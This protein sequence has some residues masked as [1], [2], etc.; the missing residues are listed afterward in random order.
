MALTFG[1]FTHTASEGVQ[2]VNLPLAYSTTFSILTTCNYDSNTDVARTAT[3]TK[4]DNSSFGI[5]AVYVRGGI[6]NEY[7]GIFIIW[8]LAISNQLIFQWTQGTFN[9]NGIDFIFPLSLNL[10]ISVQVCGRKNSIYGIDVP[11]PLTS[12]KIY[13]QGNNHTAPNTSEYGYG[14][15]L[16]Y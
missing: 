12:I 13:V 3:A 10:V 4:R 5:K 9:S 7:A 15:I 14:L 11:A 16:G 8:Q 6:S 1:I 2:Y